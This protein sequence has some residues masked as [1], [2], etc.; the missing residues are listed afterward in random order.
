MTR[1]FIVLFLTICFCQKSAAQGDYFSVG[2]GPSMIYGDNSGEYRD[3]KFKI[4][5]AIALSISKQINENLA[6]RGTIGAQPMES[7][8]YDLAYPKKIIKW[9][10]ENQAFGFTGTGYF[11]DF[12]PV[13]TTNPN[14]SG[15]LMSTLQ[16]YA[17][18]GFGMMLVE[19]EQKVLKNGSFENEVLEGD[20]VISNDSN[21]IPYI[22]LK[23]GIGT[24][25][26]GD[27]DFA[28]EYALLVTTGSKLDG[29]NIKD[30]TF[31]PDMS[32]QIMFTVKR[33]F[34]KAW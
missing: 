5:P 18:L 1:I 24:N 27:W 17:G 28:L 30:K 12:L 15:M 25:L 7:G 8:D 2:I 6:L 13:F 22:P 34:G 20:I 26:S 3:F 33:Y 21:L 32:S 23:T 16:F 14:A 9:G 11:A 10:N 4:Q 31:S 19:R 29:N